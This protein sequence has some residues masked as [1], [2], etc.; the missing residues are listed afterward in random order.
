MIPEK[1]CS[2]QKRPIVNFEYLFQYDGFNDIRKRFMNTDEEGDLY[3]NIT[4]TKTSRYLN[5]STLEFYNDTETFVEHYQIMLNKQYGFSCQNIDNHFYELSEDD[6]IKKF[7]SRTLLSLDFLITEVENSNDLN[8]FVGSKEVLI[9]LI[10]YI[11]NKYGDFLPKRVLVE[12]INY[13]ANMVNED[14]ENAKLNSAAN[15]EISGNKN[16]YPHVFSDG[17]SFNLFEKLFSLFKDSKNPI[18]DFSFVYRMMYSD[19]Y[20]LS[21]FK[22]QMFIN[23]INAEPYKISV[24]KLKTLDKCSTDAKRSTY[25]TTKELIQLK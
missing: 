25:S 22:P 16:P 21:H 17:S 4:D 5:E 20:I 9:K 3:D 6:A 24:D 7:F 2:T 15:E 10:K 13:D 12:G 14:C 23:W 1:N 8:G 19:G 18:A 11:H